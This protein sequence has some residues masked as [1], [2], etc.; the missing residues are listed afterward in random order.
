MYRYSYICIYIYIEEKESAGHLLGPR[1]RAAQ[2]VSVRGLDARD[3]RLLPLL[4]RV[5]IH[6]YTYRWIDR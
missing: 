3:R 5:Y 1:P 2:R 4:R 6:V